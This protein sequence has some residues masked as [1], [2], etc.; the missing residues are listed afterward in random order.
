MLDN[1]F[2]MCYFIKKHVSDFLGKS[3]KVA[4][5]RRKA[6]MKSMVRV[7]MLVFLAVAL[8]GCAS[9]QLSGGAEKPKPSIGL[10]AHIKKDGFLPGVWNWLTETPE[11]ERPQ[12]TS[13]NYPRP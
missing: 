3:Q 7:A 10:R 13:D 11:K 12:W 2:R 5:T 8:A 6:V 4:H 1:R 9:T